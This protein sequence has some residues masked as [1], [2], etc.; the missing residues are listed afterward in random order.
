MMKWQPRKKVS[1]NVISLLTFFACYLLVT[2]GSLVWVGRKV[3]A[4]ILSQQRRLKKTPFKVVVI[5]HKM[6]LETSSV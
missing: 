3:T 4:G 5:V 1:R 2:R 6:R